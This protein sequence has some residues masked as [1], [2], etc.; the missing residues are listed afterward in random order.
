MKCIDYSSSLIEHILFESVYCVLRAHADSNNFI[1]RCYVFQIKEIN[2][3]PRFG[4]YSL[5]LVVNKARMDI[6]LPACY[7]FQI[8]HVVWDTSYVYETICGPTRGRAFLKTILQKVDS[9]K[10]R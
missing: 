8:I 3:R 5:W 10:G 4:Y 6:V 1:L 7:T 2:E 9:S